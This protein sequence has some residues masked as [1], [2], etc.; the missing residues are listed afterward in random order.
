MAKGKGSNTVLLLMALVL[1][2]LGLFPLYRFDI[3]TQY[4]YFQLI[5]NPAH[6]KSIIHC[7]QT[8]PESTALARFL[9]TAKGKRQLQKL[10]VATMFDLIREDWRPRVLERD[11]GTN[12]AIVF[13]VTDRWYYCDLSK[14]GRWPLA[15]SHF[16]RQYGA[17]LSAIRHHCEAITSLSARFEDYPGL[18]FEFSGDMKQLCCWVWR[19]RPISALIEALQ[20]EDTTTRI[21]AVEDLLWLGPDALKAVPALKQAGNDP[22]F[23]YVVDKALRRI[24]GENYLLNEPQKN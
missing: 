24:Q 16:G 3:I 9:R 17:R 21:R 1:T 11:L 13:Q 22:D 2:V 20:S 19:P 10:F 7:W 14:G 8:T 15:G 12:E 5:H 4:H 18:S 6:L 23:K